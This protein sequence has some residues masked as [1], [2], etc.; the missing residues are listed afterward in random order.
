[1]RKIDVI[2]P[3]VAEQVVAKAIGEGKIH[4]ERVGII[5]DD[6]N[7]KIAEKLIVFW[8]ENGISVLRTKVT[9][10][11]DFPTMV[12]HGE[13]Y[14]AERADKIIAEIENLRKEWTSGII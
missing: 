1:M 5:A 12:Y 4:V 13:K 2:S 11:G 6:C 10:I 8:L 7:N 9:M 14:P 3:A